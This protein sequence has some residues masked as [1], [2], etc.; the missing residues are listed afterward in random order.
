M[1]EN[2]DPVRAAARV[3]TSLMRHQPAMAAALVMQL[4]RLPDDWPLRL[5]GTGRA[6]AAL[7]LPPT[8]P[9]AL[10]EIC[11]ADRGDVESCPACGEAGADRELHCRYHTGWSDGYHHLHQPMV[12]AVK[13]DPA[14]TVRTL[15]HR[16]ADA[17]EAA[18]RGELAAAVD[19]LLRDS[20][21]Q[22]GGEGT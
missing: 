8:P 19:H 10:P 1:T 2:T 12:E 13:V 14:T 5:F 18:E 22:E 7:D 11:P 6:D 20:G 9:G 21:A 17:D 15:L 4:R 3:W 16:L